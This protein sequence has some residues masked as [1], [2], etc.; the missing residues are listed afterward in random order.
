MSEQEAISEELHSH[1]EGKSVR[2]LI[3]TVN[4]NEL[5]GRTEWDSPEVDPEVHITRH[6]DDRN[7]RPGEFVWATITETYPFELFATLDK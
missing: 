1:L 3:E 7:V 4:E 6:P 5:I 2:V